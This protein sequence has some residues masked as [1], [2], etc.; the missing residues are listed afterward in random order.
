MTLETVIGIVVTSINIVITIIGIIQT[1]KKHKLK[2]RGFAIAIRPK[3][4]ITD[5]WL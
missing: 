1:A 5:S 3:G 2:K 4:T